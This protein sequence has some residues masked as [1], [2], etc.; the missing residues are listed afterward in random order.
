MLNSK[1][2]KLSFLERKSILIFIDLNVLI[3]SIWFS[4]FLRISNPLSEY[5]LNSVWIIPVMCSLAI[6][7]YI[8]TGFYRGL[9]TYT[10][11]SFIY[12][13]AL[14][15]IYIVLGTLTIG[16][17]SGANMPPR[18]IWVIVYILIIGINSFIKIIL[19]DFLRLFS[20]SN[21]K[22]QKVVIYGAGSAGAQLISSLRTTGAFKILFI[23]DDNKKLWKRNISGIKIKS[24]EFLKNINYKIDNVLLAIPSLNLQRR[25]QIIYKI[26]DY[27]FSILEVPSID[28]ITEGKSKIGNL[29]RINIEDLLQ[30][31]IVNPIPE[32]LINSIQNSIV[33]ITGAGGSIGSEIGLQLC[34]LNPKKLILIDSN[35]KNLYELINNLEKYNSKSNK[36]KFVLGN[37][38]DKMFMDRLIKEDKVELIFHSSAYKHVNL[39]EK[40]P[41]QGLLNNILSSYVLCHLATLHK[42]D[43][44]ILISTDKAVRPTNIMGASKRVSEL[45]FQAYNSYFE[46]TNFSIVRFGNVLN[47]SGS[48]IPLF[49]NQ[50]KNGKP[51]TITHPKVIRYFMTI[52][53]AAQLVIQSS[54][55]SKG[56]EVFLL[57]MGE[58]VEILDLAKKMI[59]LSGLTIKDKKNKDGD[60]EI[61]FTGLKSGEKLYEELLIDNK[62]KPTIHPLIYKAEET[63]IPYLEILPLI[64]ELENYLRKNDQSNSLKVLKKLVP[65]WKKSF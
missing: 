2:S 30:R 14:S 33:L 47:S 40:N 11:S 61:I 60:I 13:S 38:C 19:R 22:I 49:R 44:V 20:N 58:P 65:E 25:K 52:Q 55:L 57:D 1:I 4:F 23:V 53:E 43:K 24:P 10:G 64:K 39:V 50:I 7:I 15:N 29:R 34:K 51:L 35:E 37:C 27:G 16:Y 59:K 9:I 32:L 41:I 36:I 31:D 28:E 56:G 48:V 42:I 21:K 8:L 26:Q 17:L 5:F 18:S 45:L 6:P 54:S 63:F 46:D 3:F 12:K 62:S